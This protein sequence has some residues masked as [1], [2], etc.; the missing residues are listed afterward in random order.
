MVENVAMVVMVVVLEG[1][2]VKVD[3]T[4]EMEAG[5]KIF[6]PRMENQLL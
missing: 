6:Q 4:E 1:L 5:M 2:G 3:L